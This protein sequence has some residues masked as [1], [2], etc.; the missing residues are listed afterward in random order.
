MTRLWRPCP[1]L[2]RQAHPFQYVECSILKVLI[3]IVK[4]PSNFIV[5]EYDEDEGFDGDS[6]YSAAFSNMTDTVS[7]SSS[8]MR[9]REENGRRYHSYGKLAA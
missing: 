6:A 5:A 4:D 2:I 8:I 7:L 9:F 3:L 1:K